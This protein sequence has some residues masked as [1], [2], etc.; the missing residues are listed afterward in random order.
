MWCRPRERRYGRHAW[1]L[2]L[3]CETTILLVPEREKQCVYSNRSPASRD[4]IDVVFHSRRCSKAP[5]LRLS[6]WTFTTSKTAHRTTFFRIRTLTFLLPARARR[7]SPLLSITRSRQTGPGILPRE[8]PEN[9]G[10]WTAW[11]SRY[12]RLWLCTPAVYCDLSV[13]PPVSAILFPLLNLFVSLYCSYISLPFLVRLVA[14][15]HPYL[16]HVDSVLLALL[17]PVS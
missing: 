8:W 9:R 7:K 12:S 6:T 4:V 11:S 5:T 3:R 16:M 2:H 15:C 10:R 17:P 14:L 1:E 13:F